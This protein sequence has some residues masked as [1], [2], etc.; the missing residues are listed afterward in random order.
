[1]KKEKDFQ[2][3]HERFLI[4]P[5]AVTVAKKTA[6]ELFIQFESLAPSDPDP[7]TQFPIKA[8]R[9]F[10]SL[11]LELMG[12]TL[13]ITWHNGASNMLVNSGLTIRIY[14][15][16]R[17]SRFDF[18]R[19][20]NTISEHTYDF[21]MTEQNQFGWRERTGEKRFLESTQLAEQHF[22]IYLEKV[23]AFILRKR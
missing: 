22:R 12:F 2:E 7:Q 17:D 9:E 8:K 3:R 10:E 14:E 4:S 15:I 18:D 11:K 1:M 16:D 19:K 20:W 13:T 6:M 21:D 23:R 5:E